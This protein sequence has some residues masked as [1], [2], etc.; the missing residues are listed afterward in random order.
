MSKEMPGMAIMAAPSCILSTKWRPMPCLPKEE[1]FRYNGYKYGVPFIFSKQGAAFGMRSDD[2]LY[3]E[4]LSGNTEA[5]DELLIRYGDKLT[6]YLYGYLHSFED[7]ED[8]M[9]ESF[10]R[11]MVKRPL[12]RDGGFRAY[13]YK[14]ARNLAARVHL[15]Q[16]KTQSFDFREL[17]AEAAAESLPEEKLRIAEKKEVLQL[18]LDRIDPQYREA[19]WLI[20]MEEMSYTEA[21]AVMQIS[22]KKIDNLLFRGKQHLRKELEKE[23]VRSA[24]G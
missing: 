11:I 21:A 13:L 15:F 3:R 9:I 10:A 23:G 17:T 5:Y 12:I 24:F 6:F 1:I 7:A 8:V 19:L 22:T 4:Y 16:I 20:Y 14:T 18:C 2:E